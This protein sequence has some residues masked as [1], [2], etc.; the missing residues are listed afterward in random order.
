[1]KFNPGVKLPN[2]DVCDFWNASPPDNIHLDNV[3][4][5]SCPMSIFKYS[6]CWSSLRFLLLE[7]SNFCFSNSSLHSVKIV[8]Y[9]K[10]S[11]FAKKLFKVFVQPWN[12]IG[13][14]AAYVRNSPFF[15]L[16]PGVSECQRLS[17]AVYPAIIIAGQTLRRPLLPLTH[18]LQPP[19]HCCL[20]SWLMP[21]ADMGL[22][23]SSPLLPLLTKTLFAP[24][25]CQ[26]WCKWDIC[27]C[28]PIRSQLV[29]SH[30]HLLMM[31]ETPQMGREWR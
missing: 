23:S 20:G 8:A 19:A 26:S 9:L 28:G 25:Q 10:M 6:K 27:Q 17:R 16:S 3:L 21:L 29:L 7:S 15:S 18:N 22:T 31:S 14:G 4:E 12:C 2:L 13:G 30:H 1:M 24:S 11:T 5:A